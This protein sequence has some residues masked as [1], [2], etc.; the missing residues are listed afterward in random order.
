MGVANRLPTDDHWHGDH[1]PGEAHYLHAPAGVGGAKATLQQ[2]VVPA[3]RVGERDTSDV[4]SRGAR[5][6]VS[7][8][9]G[10]RTLLDITVRRKT[11]PTGGGRT[12]SSRLRMPGLVGRRH[13]PPKS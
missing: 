8:A 5:T 3:A 4:Q 13:G 11:A 6:L 1:L 7:L 12:H 2:E 10:W 9:A